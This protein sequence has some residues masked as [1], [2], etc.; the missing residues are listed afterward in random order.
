IIHGEV[1]THRVFSRNARSSRAVPVRKMLEE[2]RTIPFVPW[3]WGAN[4]KGMQ[5]A[6]ECNE[7]VRA[8]PDQLRPTLTRE[9]AWLV[10]RDNAALAAEAYMNAGYHKQIPNRLIEPFSW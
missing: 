2:V 6:G 5:A 3:H 1:I 8:Y 9:E 4:Q 10:A 7:K